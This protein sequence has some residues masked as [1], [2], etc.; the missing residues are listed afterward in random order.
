MFV[1]KVFFNQSH[2]DI[3]PDPCGSRLA[4]QTIRCPIS[5]RWSCRFQ[6][7]LNPVY[8]KLEGCRVSS[9]QSDSLGFLVHASAFQANAAI[10]QQF[11]SDA[12]PFER[13]ACH[14][15]MRHLNEKYQSSPMIR[16][17]AGCSVSW[18]SEHLMIMLQT[19]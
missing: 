12:Q 14:H 19:S 4:A 7:G 10:L 2:V 17:P 1:Q 5:C 8:P 6:Q 13:T 3:G 11:A 15:A 9:C 16:A 18:K